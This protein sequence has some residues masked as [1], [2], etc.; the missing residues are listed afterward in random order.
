MGRTDLYFS[1]TGDIRN[2]LNEPINVAVGNV[3]VMTSMF[4]QSSIKKVG[5]ITATSC[6][7]ATGVFQYSPAVE[8]VGNITLPSCT[9]LNNFFIFAEALKKVG[10]INAPAV[11]NI[12]QMFYQCLLLEEIVFSNCANVTNTTN[13]FYFCYALKKLIMPGLRVG[14]NISTSSMSAQALNDMF[15]SLG[16]ASGSQNIVIT[17]N[18]GASTCNTSIATSKGFTV[19]I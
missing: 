3:T 19:I 6:G 16:T 15:T 8:E 2:S 17:N 11:T 14:I 5:N 7:T 10:L 13:A 1:L 4:S 9:A 18:P 12:Q